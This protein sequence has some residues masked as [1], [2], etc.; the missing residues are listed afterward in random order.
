MIP[1]YSKEVKKIVKNINV[2]VNKM[3]KVIIKFDLDSP[4]DK[5]RHYQCVSSED[6]STALWDIAYN[7]RKKVEWEVD[8][9]PGKD[10]IDIVFER[11]SEII[12]ENGID[13]QKI[14][15]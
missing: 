7:L 5:L 13:I 15:R 3:A 11:I 12:E 10:P 14:S 4:D 8:S 1:L 9:N 2:K 6:M